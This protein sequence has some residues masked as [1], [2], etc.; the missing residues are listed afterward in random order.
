MAPRTDAEACGAV[1]GTLPRPHRL[2][3]LA[4]VRLV[5]DWAHGLSGASLL[6]DALACMIRGAGLAAEYARTSEP[7]LLPADYERAARLLREYGPHLAEPA[8]T[9][10]VCLATAALSVA[11]SE[12]AARAPAVTAD[13]RQ[14]SLHDPGVSAARAA[15]ESEVHLG[16]RT[17]ER[18]L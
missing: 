14:L 13:P 16:K 8:D 3:A 1:T 6:L 7:A 9:G 2:E 18:E 10:R 4:R 15:G 11:L 17:E 12:I 5:Q